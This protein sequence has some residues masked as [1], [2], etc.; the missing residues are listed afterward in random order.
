MKTTK[1]LIIADI[2]AKVEAKLASQKIELAIPDKIIATL[3]NV[4]Q[5]DAQFNQ[6]N[7]L[8]VKYRTE[9]PSLLKS[10]QRDLVIIEQEEAKI[11]KLVRDLGM[12]PSEMPYLKEAAE[13][14]SL[15]LKLEDR[16]KSNLK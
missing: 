3:K 16:L 13:S 5:L 12:N 2:T 7:Q 8:Y 4:K 1:E 15:L 9:A 10:I 11:S 6:L 14:F